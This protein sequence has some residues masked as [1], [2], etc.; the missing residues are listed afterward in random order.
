MI[1][2]GDVS[3]DGRITVEDVLLIKMYILKKITFNSDQM[4]A[5]DIIELGEVTVIDLTNIRAH[6]LGVKM[7]TEVVDN[8]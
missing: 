3:G 4:I 8:G 7:I 1:V 2:K 5:G 6:T